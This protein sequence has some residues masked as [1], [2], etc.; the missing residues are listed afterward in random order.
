MLSKISYRDQIRTLILEKMKT[1]QYTA[2]ESLSLV[3]IAREL[4][5]SVTPIREA[6]TQ[7]EYSG[8]V[9]SIP[10]RGFVLPKLN[11]MTAYNLYELVSS[12]EA[13]AIE[14][15]MYTETVIANLKLQQSKIESTFS[16][17]KRIN[18]DFEFHNILVSQYQNPIAHRIL[19]DTKTRIF[20]YEIE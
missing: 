2:G 6:L 9:E 13:L 7:L 4:D 18:E 15:S 11:K 8:I 17:V 10:N 3:A 20:F 16:P 19:L 1:G 14:H 5:V 12:L